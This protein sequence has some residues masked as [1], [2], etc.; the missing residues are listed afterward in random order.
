MSKK[1]STQSFIRR[2]SL[3][4]AR[5]CFVVAGKGDT[6]GAWGNTE[7]HRVT[8]GPGGPGM[9]RVGQVLT[10]WL[11]GK[12]KGYYRK[13]DTSSDTCTLKELFVYF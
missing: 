10:D 2:F 12:R 13:G 8:A 7:L 1:R 5:A 4:I 9:S 3:V 6:G 11:C